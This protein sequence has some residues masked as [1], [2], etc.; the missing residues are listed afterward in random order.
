MKDINEKIKDL[1]LYI[2]NLKQYA[3]S[4]DFKNDSRKAR[5]RLNKEVSI[6]EF[7]LRSLCEVRRDRRKDYFILK[8][9]KQKE[10]VGIY[11]DINQCSAFN[12]LTKYIISNSIKEE[13][14]P[15][16]YYFKKVSPIE[17]TQL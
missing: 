12:N 16:R 1:A 15:G 6:R 3:K 14:I 11:K 8:Y 5:H 4:V 17:L 13:Y 7:E 10:F 2:F 9:T